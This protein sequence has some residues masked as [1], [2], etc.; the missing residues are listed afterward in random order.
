MSRVLAAALVV[1]FHLAAPA[2]GTGGAQAEPFL[3]AITELESPAPAGSAQPQLSADRQ[4]RVSLSWLEERQEGGHR[5]RLARLDGTR[6]SEPV[7]LAEGSNFFANWADVPAVFVSSTGA[8]AAHWLERGADR[9]AYGIRVRTS[10]DDGR[11]WT[12]AVTP[13]RDASA[14]EHGFVSFFEAPGGRIGLVWLDGREIAAGRASGRRGSM[15]LISTTL[16]GGAPGAETEIDARVCECCPTSAARTADGVIVVYRDRSEDEIRDTAVVR[17]SGGVWS[18]PAVAHHD[19]WKIN[20]CPVN[21]PAVAALGREVALAWFTGASGAP[22]VRLA[23]SVDGGVSF[24]APR[25]IDP[26]TTRGR[27][28]LVM[29]DAGRA[30]VSS[31]DAPAEGARLV[32]REVRRDG[33]VSAPVVVAPTSADRQSGFARIAVTGRR[34]VFAWTDFSRGSPTRVKLAAATLR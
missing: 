24:S 18:A 17:L 12:A 8:M 23:F 2:R 16:S 11:T 34:V 28:G 10:S 21:G 20:A 22:E 31:L 13:H 9:M 33:R 29:P 4:G 14:A 3:G 19:N 30:L 27:I 5:F 26:Q 15:K 25:V 32:V 6:W 7:T 1:S